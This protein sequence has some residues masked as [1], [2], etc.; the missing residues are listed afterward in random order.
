MKY[1]THRHVLWHL[2]LA[3]ALVFIWFGVDKFFH[4]S[5]W[6]AFMPE[7]LTANLPVSLSAFMVMQ[8]IGETAIGFILLTPWFRFGALLAS[9]LLLAIVPMLGFN[10]V[11]IRDSA[12]LLVAAALVRYPKQ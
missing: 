1:S 2:R 11:G 4:P 6:Q 9:L 10:D 5:L 3:L 7:W 8:G 12:L